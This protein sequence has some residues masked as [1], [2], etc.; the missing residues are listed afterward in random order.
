MSVF[1]NRATMKMAD[2]AVIESNP[3]ALRMALITLTASRPV[4][5]NQIRTLI[6]A[7][8]LVLALINWSLTTT[9]DDGTQRV[10][11]GIATQVMEQGADKGW[12]I[13]ISNPSGVV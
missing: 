7:G 4:I 12:R 11:H 6:S 8:D 10:E 2:G 5:R 13:R 9:S 1:S 3:E